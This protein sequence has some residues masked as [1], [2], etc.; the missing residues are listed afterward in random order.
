MAG[1]T[2][3]CG[4][5]K[6]ARGDLVKLTGLFCSALVV[7]T[8][9]MLTLPAS[10]QESALAEAV[11]PQPP[12]VG[13][14]RT[15]TGTEI[16]VQP[17]GNK[18][19]G[20]FDYIV[21]PAKDAELCRSTPRDEFAALILD[22]KN[23]DKSLQTRQL[24]GLQAVKLQQDGKPDDYTANIYNA[25]EGKSYDVRIWVRGDT[26]TLGAGCFGGMCAVKQEW[27]RVPDRG[28]PDFTCEGGL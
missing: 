27:P 22:Y 1:R 21:I 5:D 23:P 8:F 9:G 13:T 7:L 20:S 16:K 3:R 18:F 26:L 6:S 28:A 15:L 4:P 25:E 14:W 12:V 11:A 2:F 24:L 17:C 10:A 19:C